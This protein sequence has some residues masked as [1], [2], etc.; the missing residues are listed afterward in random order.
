MSKGVIYYKIQEKEKKLGKEKNLLIFL[1]SILSCFD[2]LASAVIFTTLMKSH[3]CSLYFDTKIVYT[4][5][6]IA[7]QGTS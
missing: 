3:K 2:K 5:L 7:E 4:E 1:F 6:V